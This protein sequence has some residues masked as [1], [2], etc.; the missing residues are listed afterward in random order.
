MLKLELEHSRPKE[1][2]DAVFMK[3][4][5]IVSSQSAGELPR[6]RSQAYNLK[7]K[8][9]QE[10][11]V[12][13]IGAKVPTSSGYGM[14]DMLYLVMEQCKNAEKTFLFKMLRVHQN[15]WLSYAMNSN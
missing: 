2:V 4:G 3:R 15:L 11:L 9:Q 14:R 10:Q 8:L 13:S 12:A 6:G 1:A 7:K 5:G